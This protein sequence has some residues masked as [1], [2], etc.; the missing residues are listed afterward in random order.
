MK[1]PAHRSTPRIRPY[2]EDRLASAGP[3]PSGQP[4]PAGGAAVPA[5]GGTIHSKAYLAVSETSQL[6]GS[7][8][9]KK[10]LFASLTITE[11]A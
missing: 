4:P 7:A 10:R 5:A 9:S 11:P 6:R 3:L 1:A 8:G 2:T